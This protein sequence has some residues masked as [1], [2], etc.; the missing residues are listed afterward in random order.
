MAFSC[1]L[2]AIGRWAYTGEEWMLCYMDVR[3]KTFDL[4]HVTQDF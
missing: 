4:R 1:W 2:L 3:L